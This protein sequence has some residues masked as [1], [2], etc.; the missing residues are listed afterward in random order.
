MSFARSVTIFVVCL[1]LN[2]EN[3]DQY[4]EHLT[5]VPLFVNIVLTHIGNIL[6]THIV[7]HFRLFRQPSASLLH[8]WNSF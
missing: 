5:I 3:A 4:C 7:D 8:I 2:L 1:T 6:L